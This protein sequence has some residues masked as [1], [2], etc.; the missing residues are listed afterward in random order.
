MTKVDDGVIWRGNEQLRE[1]LVPLGAVSPHPRNPK[2]HDLGA[3]AASFARFGQQQPIVVQRSTGWIIAGNGRHAAA[4]MVGELREVL[5]L[6]SDGLWTH[7]AAVFSDLTDEEALAFALADNRTTELGGWHDEKLAD[8]LRE[9]EAK[10]AL[11]GTGYDSDDV[12]RIIAEL[13]PSIPSDLGRKEP[14]LGSE[15]TIEV[16]CGRDFLEEIQETLA[17]WQRREG[18]EVSIA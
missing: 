16:R 6:A 8:V 4:P 10:G 11:L 18:V 17:G 9:L 3:I 12:A 5:G 7:I 13:A 15:V 14:E 1:M 2:D